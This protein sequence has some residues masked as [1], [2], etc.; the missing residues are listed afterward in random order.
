MSGHRESGEARRGPLRNEPDS[1]LDAEPGYGP[2][3]SWDTPEE[4]V[5]LEPLVVGPRPRRRSWVGRQPPFFQNRFR[6]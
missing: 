5:Y 6:P 2:G 4:P 1:W 3:V